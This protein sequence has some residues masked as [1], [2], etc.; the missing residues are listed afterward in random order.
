MVKYLLCNTNGLYN[1][2]NATVQNVLTTSFTEIWILIDGCFSGWSREVSRHMYTYDWM[3]I[4]TWHTAPEYLLLPQPQAGTHE[5]NDHPL[6]Q[7]RPP[8]KCIQNINR[9]WTTNISNL[10]GRLYITLPLQC[11]QQNTTLGQKYWHDENDTHHG[12]NRM[13][14]S[15]KPYLILKTFNNTECLYLKATIFSL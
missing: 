6:P 10:T 9:K 4:L 3:I 5:I 12:G 15:I 1:K 13:S 2:F 8:L 14:Y 11:D 7:R